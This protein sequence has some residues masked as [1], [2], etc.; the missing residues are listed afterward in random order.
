[1]GALRNMPPPFSVRSL[2]E[3]WGCSEGAIRKRIAEGSLR[4]FRI[5]A[6]IR[7]AAN[8]VER[9]EQCQNTPSNDLGEDGQSSGTPRTASGTASNLPRLTSRA[10]KLRL[11]SD[12][13]SPKEVRAPWEE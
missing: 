2:A 3:H 13:D 11:A 4:T 9:V 6:L 8:E 7:I 1:M 10:P 5:G 12:G